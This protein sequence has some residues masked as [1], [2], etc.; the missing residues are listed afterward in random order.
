MFEKLFISGEDIRDYYEDIIPA[1]QEAFSGDPWYEKSKCRDTLIR[2]I[3]GLSSVAV[4]SLCTI[5][6]LRPVEQAYE[7]D[8][9][10]QKFNTITETKKTIWYLE[11]EKTQIA[12]AAFA[13]LSDAQILKNERYSDVPGMEKWLEDKIQGN[14]I[15]WLDEVFAQKSIRQSGNLENFR[16]MCDGI[17]DA[18]SA[19]SIAFRTINPAMT[20][21]AQR[22]YTDQVTVYQRNEAVPDRRDFVII[23]N[24]GGNT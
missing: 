23:R 4:G 15:V 9:L 17:S 11:K 24:E 2:C 5:C 19:D 13:W 10:L 14:S 16:T 3:G 8:E 18:L 20:R 7:K 1:Y 6:D 12:L 21:A 22:D